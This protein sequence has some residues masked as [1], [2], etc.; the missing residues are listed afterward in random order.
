MGAKN[1]SNRA[2]W[3][4]GASITGRRGENEFVEKL[5]LHLPKHY[6]IEVKP[7]K[8]Q[9]YPDGKGVV[10]DSK[11]VN[12]KTDRCIYIEKK[13]GNN[14]GNAHERVYKFLSR[15]LKKRVSEM[16]N[17][18]DNPFILIFSGDTFQRQKYQDELSLLLE[19]EE[20]AVMK[21]GFSNISDVADR[22]MEII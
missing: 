19:G 3:Q 18:P 15:A 13:T 4:T 8:L 7:P 9:I 2:N 14:G 17:T 6:I 16:Y 12:S 20:Y 5:A 10:L 1:L 11:V 22:I 21:P